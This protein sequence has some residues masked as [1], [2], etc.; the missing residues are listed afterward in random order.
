M[1]F[2]ILLLFIF[3]IWLTFFKIKTGTGWEEAILRKIVPT[4]GEV[5]ASCEKT[6][7]TLI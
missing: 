4:H 5:S 2:F 3:P 7:G 6:P 1:E